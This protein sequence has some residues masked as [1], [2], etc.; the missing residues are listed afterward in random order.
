M[1]WHDETKI[2]GEK[3]VVKNEK[4]LGVVTRIDFEANLV[5]VLF[6]KMREVAYP[7]PQALEQGYIQVKFRSR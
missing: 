4:E 1:A 6:K 3:V 7:F 5:Y 2:I